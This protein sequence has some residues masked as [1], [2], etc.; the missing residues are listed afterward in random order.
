MATNRYNSEDNEKNG[1]ESQAVSSET[2][3]KVMHPT[4]WWVNGSLLVFIL[5]INRK[6][7]QAVPKICLVPCKALLCTS[8][9][10][11][12]VN[13]YKSGAIIAIWQRKA[14]QRLS[15]LSRFTGQIRSSQDS[16]PD[17]FPSLI[18]L[19]P[20]HLYST[21]GESATVKRGVL[22]R[23][24]ERMVVFTER[25]EG[26]LKTP[27][28]TQGST[29]WLFGYLARLCLVEECESLDFYNLI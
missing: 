7:F 9:H 14:A 23:C 13:S 17:P 12:P 1:Q 29:P 26:E 5:N 25:N 8:W 3:W 18:L 16:G 10:W 4:M 21:L 22:S 11:I 2:F 19:F 28:L 6:Q 15:D 20:T 27:A 24:R